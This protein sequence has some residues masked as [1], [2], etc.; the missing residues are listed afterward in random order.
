MAK[1]VTNTIKSRVLLSN[2]HILGR[3]SNSMLRANPT[4]AARSITYKKG[5]NNGKLI[6]TIK[7]ISQRGGRLDTKES[8]ENISVE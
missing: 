1:S 5:S 2:S 7:A 8:F 3:Q 4:S 6:S